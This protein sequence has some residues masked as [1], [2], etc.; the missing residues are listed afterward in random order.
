MTE[1]YKKYLS[2]ESWKGKSSLIINTYGKCAICNKKDNLITHHKTYKNIFNEKFE[3]LECICSSCHGIIHSD[4][5]KNKDI[6]DIIYIQNKILDNTFT[7]SIPEN[8]I[9]F[10]IYNGMDEYFILK[11]SKILRQYSKKDKIKMLNN[12][13]QL[14]IIK[15]IQIN[16]NEAYIFFNEQNIYKNFKCEGKFTVISKSELYK[17]YKNGRALNIYKLCCKYLW[18]SSIK[19]PIEKFVKYF[20]IKDGYKTNDIETKIIKPALNIIT[21]NTKYN[22]NFVKIKSDNQDKKRIS[23]YRIDVELKTDYK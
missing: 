11:Y 17:I 10:H 4:K 9:L 23:H 20:N 5:S 2:S 12:L 18:L 21:K 3:D 13:K 15:N 6:N 14:D 1:K 7:L 16:E 19:I 8:R 22:T